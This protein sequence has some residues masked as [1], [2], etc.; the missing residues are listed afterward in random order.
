MFQAP[1]R[2]TY[3]H[4]ANFHDNSWVIK[5]ELDDMSNVIIDDAIACQQALG[6][7]QPNKVYE[8]C[9][10][11]NLV[12]MGFNARRKVSMLLHY[13]D[14]NPFRDVIDV[15]GKLVIECVYSNSINEENYNNIMLDVKSSGYEAGL[16]INFAEPLGYRGIIKIIGD[17]IFTGSAASGW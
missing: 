9:L 1:Q 4:P 11:N 8:F 16:F 7:G 3:H 6:M 15:D 12:K 2:N 13:P 17:E 14:A 5:P 10:F